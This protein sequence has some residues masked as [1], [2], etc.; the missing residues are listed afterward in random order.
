MKSDPHGTRIP[1]KRRATNETNKGER[2]ERGE[3]G[4]RTR[5]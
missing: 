1:S 2:E 4:A 5:G 3:R